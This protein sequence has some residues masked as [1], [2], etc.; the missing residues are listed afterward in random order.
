MA[1]KL[2]T[3]FLVLL[4]LIALLWIHRNGLTADEAVG[5]SAGVVVRLTV[6]AS[7][8]EYRA[9]TVLAV[10]AMFA[11]VMWTVLRAYGRENKAKPPAKESSASNKTVLR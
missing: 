1:M 6:D 10:I 7:Y 5:K 2:V 8:N 4:A 11:F 9:V 3:S